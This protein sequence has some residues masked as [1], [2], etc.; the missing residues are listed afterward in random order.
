MTYP[1]AKILLLELAQGRPGVFKGFLMARGSWGG[2]G[3][4]DPVKEKDEHQSLSKCLRELA[5]SLDGEV[6][7]VEAKV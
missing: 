5:D 7:R 1:H 6:E 4:P 2:I 3:F